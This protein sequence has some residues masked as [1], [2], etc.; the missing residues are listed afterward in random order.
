[1][2]YYVLRSPPH[3]WGQG[4]RGALSSLPSLPAHSPHPLSIP[5]SLEPPWAS[6]SPQLAPLASSLLPLLPEHPWVLGTFLR[7]QEA[8]S[9]LP[10]LPA[11]SPYSQLA[12]LALRASLGL[13]NLLGA[14]E[15]SQL[16]LLAPRA[17][18]DPWNLPEA[19][20]SPEIAPLTSSLLSSLPACFPCFQ[21]IPGSLEPSWG[22]RKPSACSPCYQLAALTPSLLPLLPE[23][24]WVPGTFL[25]PQK[26]PS[27]LSLLPACSPYSGSPDSQL[28]PKAPAHSPHSQ[29]T[30]LAPRASLDPWSKLGVRGASWE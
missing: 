16:A 6:G 13:W 8:P 10:L 7:P 22:L 12:P 9:L 27:L 4:V 21:S 20:G 2:L 23:H 19:S 15:S 3:L 28:A 29:L 17:S 11:C 18:L 5:G 30:P 24:P 14:S 26:A 1:M 25:G